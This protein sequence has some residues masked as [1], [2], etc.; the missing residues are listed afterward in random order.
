MSRIFVL[1]VY[2]DFT[3]SGAGCVSCLPALNCLQCD[4][5]DKC[6]TCKP[7]FSLLPSTA[8]G[9]CV[10]GQTWSIKSTTG[11]FGVVT[12]TGCVS[13]TPANCLRYD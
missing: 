6:T 12:F 7:T 9:C 2:D 8:D 11:A 1:Y 4:A 5:T 13:C 3:K 10:A